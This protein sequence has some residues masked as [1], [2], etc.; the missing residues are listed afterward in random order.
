MADIRKMQLGQVVDFVIDYNDR[1]TRSEK[2]RKHEEKH[3]KKR[4]A[5]Q[6]DINAFFG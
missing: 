5:T 6:S 1:V 4:K 2:K 3:G